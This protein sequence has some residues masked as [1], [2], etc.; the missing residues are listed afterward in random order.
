MRALLAVPFSCSPRCATCRSASHHPLTNATAPLWE[1]S[2]LAPTG[3]GAPTSDVVATAGLT[4]FSCLTLAQAYGLERA[5][6]CWRAHL[7]A[8]VSQLTDG[9]SQLGAPAGGR[10]AAVQQLAE[11]RVEELAALA[12]DVLELAGGQAREMEGLRHKA[13]QADKERHKLAAFRR[14]VQEHVRDFPG[15]RDVRAA[16]KADVHA[17]G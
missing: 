3:P 9:W 16:V 1:V 4:P 11:L 17:V 14:A 10:A 15:A 13:A 2:T 8:N 12:A 7:L 6:S 5:A